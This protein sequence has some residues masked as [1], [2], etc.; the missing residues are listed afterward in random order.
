M[1]SFSAHHDFKLLYCHRTK[2]LTNMVSKAQYIIHIFS[3]FSSCFCLKSDEW[4]VCCNLD[5]ILHVSSVKNNM[6]SMRHNVQA[7][8]MLSVEMYEQLGAFTSNLT[9]PVI[10]W[11]FLSFCIYILVLKYSMLHCCKTYHNLLHDQPFTMAHLVF[12]LSNRRYLLFKLSFFFNIF[13]I[14]VKV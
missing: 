13:T 12:L 11:V 1:V 5:S 2:F 3:S 8:I 9:L 4:A 10:N 14:V 6:T 7:Q